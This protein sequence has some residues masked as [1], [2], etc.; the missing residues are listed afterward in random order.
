MKP[1]PFTYHRPSGVD[2][3][4]RG[5][6]RG[7]RATARCWPAGR[8]WC[9]SCRCGW[10]RPATSSTST[11]WPSWPTCAPTPDGVRVGALARHAAVERDERRR[12]GAAAAAAGAAPRRPPDDP[13]PR[14]DGRQP[15]ARR[16]G[17]RDAGG[18]R[19]C[20]AG[21]VDASRRSP[22]DARVVAGGRLLPRP[23]GVGGRP[24]ELAVEAFFPAPPHGTG[25]AFVEVARRH[26]DYALCGVAAVGHARRRT[27]SHARVA[28]RLD[29]PDPGGRRPRPT[30][31]PAR[32]RPT[33]RLG[34][35]RRARRVA[36]SSPRTTST[37][38]PTTGATSRGVLTARALAEAWSASGRRDGRRMASGPEDGTERARCT[39]VAVTVNGTGRAPASRCRPRRLLSDAC[40]TT[41]A[42]RHPRRLRARRLRRLHR[43]ARRRAGA[44]LPAVRGR[45]S[46]GPRSPPSRG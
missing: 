46:T 1:S 35:R 36:D 8:A 13:Q 28:L 43:P 12:R 2:E 18:A 10:R 44:L 16:P 45:P 14:H 41:W 19:C 40:A 5:A 23:A 3:A 26:G 31:S 32:R 30:R 27:A 33:G 20:S 15:R 34:G 25:T 22:G 37:P 7:R 38:P 39:T 21:R 4:A 17:R 42:D 11:G 9:R 29:G 24:G 6:R